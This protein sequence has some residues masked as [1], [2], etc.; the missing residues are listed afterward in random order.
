MGIADTNFLIDVLMGDS[1]ALS[2]LDRMI[3]RNE[4]VWIPAPAL[5]ELYYGAALSRRKKQ[6]IGLIE[7]LEWAM[8]C[9]PYGGEAARKA[10]MLEGELERRGRRPSRMD[11]QIAAIA[12][13][14][15]EPVITKDKDFKRI[16]GV[17]TQEYQGP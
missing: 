9:I 7:Q 8:P 13:V 3:E 12:L 15:D 6:Q 11:L 2:A 16:P 5:H 1:A 17:K 14:R 10:G 4:P